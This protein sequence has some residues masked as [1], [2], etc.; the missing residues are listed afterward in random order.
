MRYDIFKHGTNVR[1]YDKFNGKYGVIKEIRE[2]RAECIEPFVL[3]DGDHDLTRGRD[4]YVAEREIKMT[5][6]QAHQTLKLFHSLCDSY[7]NDEFNEMS[8]GLLQATLEMNKEC[9]VL[10]KY[11]K[12]KSDCEATRA[13]EIFNYRIMIR[14][15]KLIEC[16]RK[17][18]IEERARYFRF[19][20]E[21]ESP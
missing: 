11:L 16:G 15:I 10:I 1:V 8:P 20:R 7:N 6:Q 21:T 2:T 9:R 19:I 5:N 14:L 3:F 4:L 13:Y 17:E 12:S 18:T